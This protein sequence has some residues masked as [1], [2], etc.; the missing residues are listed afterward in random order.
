[1][2]CKEVTDRSVWDAFLSDQPESQFLQSWNWGEFQRSA[3]A[4]IFRFGISE[5]STIIA[6]VQALLRRHGLGI[7]SLTVYRG[8]ILDQKLPLEKYKACFDT[9]I[10][11]LSNTARSHQAT[12]LHLEPAVS[13]NSPSARLYNDLD[14]KPAHSDQPEATWLLDLRPAE[15]ELLAAMH[16]KMRYNIR[17]AERKGV[18]VQEERGENISEQFLT[19][20]HQTANRKNIHPHPDAYFRKMLAQPDLVQAY[21]A[22]QNN[23]LLAMNIMLRFGDTV[24]YLHGASSDEGRNAMAPHLLQWHQICEAKRAGARWYDF[25]GIAPAGAGDTHPWAG[26]SRFKRGFGGQERRWLPSWEQPIRKLQYRLVR[27]RRRL[28]G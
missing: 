9:L 6:A 7:S 22:S 10:R 4:Q 27:F 11:Q 19:L 1:M 2:E 21:S 18:V 25:G 28:R 24:M 3:G 15:E 23:Q 16:E 14:W 13:S 26:I 17:L 12:Y 5:N 20:L 8:P